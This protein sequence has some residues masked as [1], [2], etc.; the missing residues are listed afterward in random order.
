MRINVVFEVELSVDG[1][2]MPSHDDVL[3]AM[4]QGFNYPAV[5]VEPGVEDGWQVHVNSAEWS[6]VNEGVK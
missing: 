2:A 5:V 6:I 4:V 1:D 3:N